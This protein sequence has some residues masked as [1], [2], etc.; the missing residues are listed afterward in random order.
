MVFS[1]QTNIDAMH[2]SLNITGQSLGEPWVL[3]MS[4]GINSF[5]KMLQTTSDQ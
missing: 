1:N 3:K 2:H 4:I 5:V